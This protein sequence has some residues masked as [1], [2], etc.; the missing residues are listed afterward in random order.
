MTKIFVLAIIALFITGQ[1]RPA[2][3]KS[4]LAEAQPNTSLRPSHMEVKVKEGTYFTFVLPDR[5]PDKYMKR[6]EEDEET[7]EHVIKSIPASDFTW[8]VNGVPGGNAVYGTITQD[9]HYP[10][11]VRYDA[12]ATLPDV[13]PVPIEARFNGSTYYKRDSSLPYQKETASVTITDDY[14][15]TFV[16]YSTVGVLHMID[17]SSCKIRISGKD[18]KLLG[19]QNYPPWSDWPPK[20]GGC[21]YT[22][23]DKGGWKGLVDISG[24]ASASMDVTRKKGT[25]HV[26]INLAPAT[27]NTPAILSKC[28]GYTVPIPA[29]T[30]PAQPRTIEFEKSGDDIVVFYAGQSNKNEIKHIVNGEGFVVRIEH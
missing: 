24:M 9:A 3:A 17:S 15:F 14:Q 6:I 22:Y 21:A 4:E 1:F 5:L 13:N 23:P 29:H 11:M 8:F 18:A 27:G 28:P 19:I 2:T 10:L 7:Y 25:M 30:F 16:G 20:A 26:L 12:P